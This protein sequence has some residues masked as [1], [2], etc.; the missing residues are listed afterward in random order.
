MKLITM[1]EVSNADEEDED[2]IAKL[3]TAS[4]SFTYSSP[5]FEADNSD[6][7]HHL[8]YPGIY[9]CRQ[10]ARQCIS[11]RILNERKEKVKFQGQLLDTVR[12]RFRFFH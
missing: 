7:V 5:V 10:F 11:H 8:S 4:L 2:T 12:L 1:V 9:R 6:I 3:L